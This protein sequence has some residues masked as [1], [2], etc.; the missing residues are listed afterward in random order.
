MFEANL[1][2]DDYVDTSSQDASR[3]CEQLID[4]DYWE[5]C[6]RTSFLITVPD[7]AGRLS[8][9]YKYWESATELVGSKD[10]A[11]PASLAAHPSRVSGDF[12]PARA[13]CLAVVLRSADGVGR[14]DKPALS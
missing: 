7:R 13:R 8:A 4:G 14:K 6:Q 3:C 10:S 1:E 11:N 2:G 9:F 12:Q 5:R